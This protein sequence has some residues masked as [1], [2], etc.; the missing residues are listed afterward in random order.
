MPKGKN[1][2]SK[3]V[4]DKKKEAKEIEESELLARHGKGDDQENKDE[5]EEKDIFFTENA[6]EDEDED[7][8]F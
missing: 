6:V 5:E 1:T 4:K 8:I 3:V 2:A 7:V